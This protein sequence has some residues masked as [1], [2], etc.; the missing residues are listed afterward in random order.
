MNP[1]PL[2]KLKVRLRI[3]RRM[4]LIAGFKCEGI[5]GGLVI[6]AEMEESSGFTGKR[7]VNKMKPTDFFGEWQA[8]IEGAGDSAII[9][10]ATSRLVKEF[11]AIRP[12]DS[13]KV[14]EAIDNVLDKVHQ[15]YIDPDPRCQGLSLIIA[16]KYGD[17]LDL[18]S[19]QG[20]T[21]KPESGS[22]C[23]G[24][25][26]DLATYLADRLYDPWASLAD[27]TKIATIILKEIKNAVRSCGLGSEITILHKE[28][29]TFTYFGREELKIIEDELP[30]FGDALSSYGKQLHV[31]DPQIFR[32]MLPT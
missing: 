9:D 30:N 14:L 13:E 16:L 21:P 31:A 28:G 2:N 29:R 27:T 17:K 8:V 15:K 32:L 11:S 24:M 22:V 19:T 25:G 18:I 1:K 4:T 10:N 6:A 12:F 5:G 23:I 26:A 7:T 3:G 20:R